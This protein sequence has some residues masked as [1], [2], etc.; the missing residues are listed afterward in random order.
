MEQKEETKKI[1]DG[2]NNCQ[3][4]QISLTE[5]RGEREG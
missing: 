2:T 3:E 5:K 1:K 4:Q